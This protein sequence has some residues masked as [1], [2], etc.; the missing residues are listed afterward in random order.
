LAKKETSSQDSLQKLKKDVREKN[1]GNLYV[2]FGEET[3]LK[4]HYLEQI[5]RQRT[6][7][8]T[9]SFNYRKLT[10]ETFTMEGLTEGIEAVP[11]M[12]EYTLTVV[13]DVDIWKLNEG[14]RT[15]LG[16]LLSDI[17]D[18]CTVIFT[19]ETVEW[20]LDGRYKK[21]CDI[22]KK[23]AEVVEFPK[24]EAR[25]LIPWIG[26]HFAA[27]KKRIAPNLCNYLIEMTDGTMTTLAGEIGKICAFS[28]TEEIT[29]SDIDAVVEP[30]L[31]AI[32]YDISDQL[33]SGEP[34]KALQKLE[35]VLKMQ[36]EPISILGSI[37][38]HFRRLSTA[39]VLQDGGRSYTELMP[40]Y[41][42]S[43]LAARKTMQSASRL[44]PKFLEKTAALIMETDQK[45]KTSTDDP[46]RLLEVLLLEIS[47]EAR[48]G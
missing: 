19:Y 6:D 3:F 4:N 47:R 18:Y 46:K 20:K 7:E 36:E 42:M 29:K 25:D 17:P 16:E 21:L 28:G 11:M 37:G 48:N 30:A 44:S 10:S 39:R 26:R 40:L 8:I 12:A 24:Q 13:D 41:R 35:Q 27:A 9:E 45:M 5:R 22:I 2:F 32:I 14:D 1:V 43:D 31:D 15:H 23:Y 33:S 38:T 34:G